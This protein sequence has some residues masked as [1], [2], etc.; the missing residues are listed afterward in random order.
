MT[1]YIRNKFDVIRETDEHVLSYLNSKTVHEST[2]EKRRNQALAFGDFEVLN[3]YV[4]DT[5][6]PAGLELHTITTTAVVIIANMQKQ[7]VITYLIARP[8]QLKRYG[9]KD[10]NILKLA[11]EHKIYNYN[12][13]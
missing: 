4:V 11:E 10:K 3:S 5:G 2:R 9:I 6:H 7:Q 8:Q 12:E 1:D 13:L